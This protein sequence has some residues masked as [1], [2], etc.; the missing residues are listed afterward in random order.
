MKQ[1]YE[2]IYFEFK[3]ILINVVLKYNLF[4]FE[5]SKSVS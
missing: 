5:E 2:I 1:A 4:I 3:I